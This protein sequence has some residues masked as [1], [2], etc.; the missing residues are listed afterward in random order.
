MHQWF[1]T[2]FQA[3]CD[4]S[5]LLYIHTTTTLISLFKTS[6]TVTEQAYTIICKSIGC[7]FSCFLGRITIWKYFKH[8]QASS[9]TPS[10]WLVGW[11]MSFILHEMMTCH[12]FIP[13]PRYGCP[14]LLVICFTNPL[15]QS[16]ETTDIFYQKC[17]CS[18]ITAC[19]RMCHVALSTPIRLWT[20]PLQPSN[21]VRVGRA[22]SI[23]CACINPT[24]RLHSLEFTQQDKNIHR[25]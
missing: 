16:F 13:I 21:L 9:I 20:R 2:L 3:W 23:I 15:R 6:S 14:W 8:Y 5:V 4:D 17:T 1:N 11:H 19:L 7:H 12:F 24:E 25:M 10:H 18:Y 22:M